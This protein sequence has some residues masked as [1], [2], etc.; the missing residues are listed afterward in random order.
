M[1]QRCQ[2]SWI[3]LFS[4]CF[5]RYN[6][7]YWIA[8]NATVR[9]DCWVLSSCLNDSMAVGVTHTWNLIIVQTI[10]CDN[11]EIMKLLI[12]RAI[13][14][15]CKSVSK[16]DPLFCSHLH[17]EM[18]LLTESFGLLAVQHYIYI[19]IMVA[20]CSRKLRE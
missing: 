19:Y 12:L 9:V 8:S 11:I 18:P 20:A 14:H 17:P 5:R 1:K 10:W 6:T 15:C 7:V 3:N 2:H 13:F 4:R 16:I